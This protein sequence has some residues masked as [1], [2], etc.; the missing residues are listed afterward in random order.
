LATL[1]SETKLNEFAGNP[2]ESAEKNYWPIMM[3][4]SLPKKVLG[5]DPTKSCE[6]NSIAY[7]A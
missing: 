7:L 2:I 1:A 5:T 3:Q 4:T 6:M